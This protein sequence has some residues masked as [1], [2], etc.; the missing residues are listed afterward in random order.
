MKIKT[1]SIKFSERPARGSTKLKG[2]AS[3]TRIIADIGIA[4]RDCSSALSL[5][6][7]LSSR[8]FDE[9][10]SVLTIGAATSFVSSLNA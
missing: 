3:K 5:G 2:M 10:V 1:A 4:K 8:L 9:I 6:L 7:L